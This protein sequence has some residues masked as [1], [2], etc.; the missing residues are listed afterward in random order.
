MA[1][2]IVDLY[3]DAAGYLSYKECVICGYRENGAYKEAEKHGAETGV[4]TVPATPGNPGVTTYYCSVCGK[5]LRTEPLP[6]LIP[7]P[8]AGGENA[9]SSKSSN[10]NATKGS[11]SPT[12]PSGA[13]ATNANSAVKAAD[14]SASGS[15]GVPLKNPSRTGKNVRGHASAAS[16]PDVVRGTDIKYADVGETDWC[17]GHIMFVQSRGIMRGTHNEPALFSPDVE[18]SR[19]ML[20]TILYNIGSNPEV[21]GFKAPFTDVGKGAYY[22]DAVIWAASKEY[23]KG[24]GDGFFGPDD[25][26]TRQDFLTIL[27]R[28]ADDAGIGLADVSEYA[29]FSDEREISDYA[30]D[31]VKR[32]RK[33]GIIV[34]KFSNSFDPLGSVTRAEAAAILHR[35][36]EPSA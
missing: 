27:L 35:L 1:E 23:I 7:G 36:L 12:T 25:I 31:A 9:S 26:L 3:C 32:C 18:L 30:S 10:N 34:G 22:S 5:E 19:G 4:V 21:S 13:G 6:A 28:Y 17:Y 8:D 33:A 16:K 2:I 20:A 24:Y 15:G 14:E 11:I 29:V